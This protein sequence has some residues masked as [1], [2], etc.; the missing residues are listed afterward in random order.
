MEKIKEQIITLELELLKPEVR[1][2][3]LKLDQLLAD[4]FLEFASIGF[5]FGKQQ[6]LE[7]LPRED[8]PQFHCQD[9]DIKHLS[10]K[11]VLLTYRS[12]M[13]R[14]YQAENRYSLRSSIWKHNETGWQMTFHQG[15]K[16]EAF[17]KL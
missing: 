15:T 14:Q 17:N 12:I 10:D 11:L 16:C 9:F 2:S 5:S 13:K 1:V 7:R 6:A 4:D 3:K 8:A